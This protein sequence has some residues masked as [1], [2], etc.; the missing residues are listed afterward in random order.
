DP[1]ATAGP[2]PGP[3]VANPGPQ[4]TAGPGSNN[5]GTGGSGGSGGPSGPTEPNYASDVGV[6]ADTIKVG[7][8]FS[9]TGPLGPLAFAPG[10]EGAIAYFNW[11]NTQGGINGRRV[12][13]VQCDDA[14]DPERNKQCTNFLINE[15]EVFALVATYTR[16]YAGAE[17]VSNAGVPDVGGQPIGN[18]YTTWPT[19]FS[20][21]GSEYP[22]DG[23]VGYEGQ[24]WSQGLQFRWAKQNLGITHVGVVFYDIPVSESFATFI[25]NAAP[26]EGLEVTGY[27]VNAAFPNFDSVASQMLAEGVDGVWDTIDA[28][29]NQ[30]LCEALERKAVPIKGKIS[31]TQGFTRRVD[32]FPDYCKDVAYI[33]GESRPN[34]DVAHPEV[35]L[36]RD[37]IRQTY[38]QEY[39]DNLHQ[40]ALEGWAAAKMF[41]DTAASMGADLTRVGLMER[42]ED[43]ERSNDPNI[44][45][46]RLETVDGLLS[47]IHWQ[48]IEY[49]TA[50]NDQRECL[51]ISKWD[52]SIRNFKAVTTVPYCDRGLSWIAYTPAT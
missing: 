24:L 41:S 36:F 11:L 26:S 25:Q 32:Q 38:G 42:L 50:G 17:D 33:W 14:E 22:R 46:S 2:N 9:R 37:V 1:S 27:R 21:R 49:S 48:R 45:L 34:S 3:G 8:L 43:F 4:P 30:K 20:I 29:G 52:Q 6:T 23:E 28:T 35:K 19:L 5:G 15:E 31:T 18:E 51:I 40:W 47:P 10:A 7:V 39:D 12:E 13:V 16:A 44:P